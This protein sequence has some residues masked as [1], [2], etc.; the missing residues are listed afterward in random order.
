MKAVAILALGAAAAIW[1]LQQREAP[2]PPPP[3]KAAVAKP[4]PAPAPVALPKPP[5]APALKKPL[6]LKEIPAEKAAFEAPPAALVAVALPQPPEP[7]RADPGGDSVYGWGAWSQNGSSGPG[8]GAPMPG[9]APAHNLT[10]ALP[11]TPLVANAG[12]VTLPSSSPPVLVP[13]LDMR[14]GHG[15]GDGNHT[16]RHQPPGRNR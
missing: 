2:A 15:W 9:A 16:H 1:W 5:P 8:P 12:S 13:P 10:H 11:A 3:A 14:P 7:P 4:K 6:A